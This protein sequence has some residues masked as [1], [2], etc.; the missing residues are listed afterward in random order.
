MLDLGEFPLYKAWEVL[1]EWT[2]QLGGYQPMKK[3]MALKVFV[4]L[5]IFISFFPA[6][7]SAIEKNQVNSV[8]S[9]ELNPSQTHKKME[10]I[11]PTEENDKTSFLSDSWDYDND[12]IPNY[13]DSDADGDGIPEKWE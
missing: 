2:D 9:S 6:K 10:I 11:P 4:I 7:L 13:L 12:G 5:L 3:Y 1:Y 8:K